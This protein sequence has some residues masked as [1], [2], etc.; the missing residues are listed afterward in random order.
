MHIYVLSALR[1]KEINIITLICKCI[2]HGYMSPINVN[3]GL[4]KLSLWLFDL[5]HD[6]FPVILSAHFCQTES[7]FLW[8]TFGILF[9]VR[10]VDA[11]QN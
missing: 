1:I 4:N 6:L 3:V 8:H 2:I 10:S 9:Y 11:E 7:F 5:S